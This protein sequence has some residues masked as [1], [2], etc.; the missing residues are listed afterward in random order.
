MTDNIDQLLALVRARLTN[1][2]FRE[3]LRGIL[4]NEDRRIDDKIV[5]NYLDE[6]TVKGH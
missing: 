3:A 2:E 1:D 5:N 6:T 4:E